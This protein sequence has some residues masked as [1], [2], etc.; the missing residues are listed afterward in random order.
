M[1]G[2]VPYWLTAWSKQDTRQ[3]SGRVLRIIYHISQIDPLPDRIT[4]LHEDKRHKLHTAENH[5]SF[6]EVQGTKH[7]QQH[8]LCTE[9]ISFIA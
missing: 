2:L 9:F 3:Y 6:A 5:N 4:I 7:F 8:A 1:G